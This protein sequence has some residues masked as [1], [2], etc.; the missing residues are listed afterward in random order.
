MLFSLGKAVFRGKSK[1]DKI[2]S[3]VEII[4]QPAIDFANV[5]FRFISCYSVSEFLR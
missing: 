3:L 4:F 5:P 2:I 1:D